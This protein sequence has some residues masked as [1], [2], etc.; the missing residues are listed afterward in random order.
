ML[1]C[2][3][4]SSPSFPKLAHATASNTA[5][6]SIDRLVREPCHSYAVPC[7]GCSTSVGWHGSCQ[8]QVS[9]VLQ[10]KWQMTCF[11]WQ[12]THDI[13]VHIKRL[14]LKKGCF[15]IHVKKIPTIAGCHLAT[16]SKSWSCGS[17]RIGLLEILLLV[18]E[19]SQYPSGFALRKL[20]C[21]SVLIENLI[22]IPGFVLKMFRFSEH[23]VVSELTLLFVHEISSWPLLLLLFHRWPCSDP[24][25]FWFDCQLL[26]GLQLVCCWNRWSLH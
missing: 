26:L 9:S 13:T 22:V 10:Q 23:F 24:A 17:R 19:N 21:W 6:N 16:H 8:V 2:D 5:R 7:Q 20:P 11:W 15:E 14:P 12:L 25:C 3:G 4:P 18:L 1:L